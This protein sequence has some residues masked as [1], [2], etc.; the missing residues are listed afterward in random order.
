MPHSEQIKE[1]S[2]RSFAMRKEHCFDSRHSFS[3]DIKTSQDTKN[4][5]EYTL[6]IVYWISCAWKECILDT[7]HSASNR[8]IRNTK[9]K[10]KTKNKRTLPS[11]QCYKMRTHRTQISIY[12]RFCIKSIYRSNQMRKISHSVHVCV[13]NAEFIIHN[14]GEYDTSTKRQFH[15]S[16]LEYIVIFFVLAS[17]AKIDKF[18][19]CPSREH[20]TYN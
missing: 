14:H 16:A 12:L 13:F 11:T 15:S 4:T 7:R 6:Y 20:A 9:K 8:T 17:C 18:L 5:K 19:G 3:Y 1:S 2:S 10:T